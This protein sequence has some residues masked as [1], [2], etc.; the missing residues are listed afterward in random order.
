MLSQIALLGEREMR[1]PIDYSEAAAVLGSGRVVGAR[2]S[3]P[4]LEIDEH[5]ARCNL[6][7]GEITGTSEFGY[8]DCLALSI[9]D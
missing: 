6:A 9:E 2:I 5:Q 7:N 3:R 4:V 8:L 1:F